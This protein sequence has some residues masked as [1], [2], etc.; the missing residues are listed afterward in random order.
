MGYELK[1]LLAE[2]E[3]GNRPVVLLCIGTD[4][5]TGDSLGPLIGYKL[6][7][8]RSLPCAVYGTLDE[9]VHAM[10]LKDV[11]AMI[12][13]D[14]PGSLVVAIDASLGSA[15]HIGFVTM[16]CG[17]IRPGLGVKKDLPAVGDIFIT[18][19]VNFSGLLDTLL[20]QTTRLSTVMKL[21]DCISSALFSA[22]I[23]R[24]QVLLQPSADYALP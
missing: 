12:E 19:I 22:L 3:K 24:E 11:M 20:L 2:H 18:G 8:R 10:N 4:R 23:Y 5:S 17:S 15:S 9:P 21:A 13:Q 16:G 1:S 14:H 6:S 7:K